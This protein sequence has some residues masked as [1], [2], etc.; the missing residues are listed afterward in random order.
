MPVGIVVIVNG[1]I[2]PD[3]FKCATSYTVLRMKVKAL[4]NRRLRYP[5]VQRLPHLF[6]KT[7]GSEIDLIYSFHPNGLRTILELKNS[8]KGRRQS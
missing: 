2:H 5:V 8:P 7:K 4:R 1:T 6:R 3:I